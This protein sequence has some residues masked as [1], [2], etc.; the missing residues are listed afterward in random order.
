MF[1]FKLHPLQWEMENDGETVFRAL[2]LADGTYMISWLPKLSHQPIE[3]IFTQEEV[4]K[5][6]AL[7]HWIIT[8]E[9]GEQTT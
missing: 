6:M 4:T 8:D 7:G 3:V 1:Y 9:N 5:E 2:E